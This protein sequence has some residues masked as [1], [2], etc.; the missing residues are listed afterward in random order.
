MLE[1]VVSHAFQWDKIHQLIQKKRVPQALLLVGPR[2]ANILQFVNRFMALLICETSPAPCGLCRACHLLIEGIHPDINYIRRESPT[3]AIKID[4]VR[5]LQHNIY[6]T[7]QR[8]GHRFIVIES[9]DKMNTAAANA[10]LKIL[11]EPP[12]HTRFILIAEQVSSI[13]ATILSRCQKLNFPSLGHEPAGYMTIGAAYPEGSI[14]AALMLQSTSMITALCDLIEEKT[15]P[16][17]IAARWSVD[18]IEDIL[19][20]LYLV[21]AEAIHYQLIKTNDQSPAN[22]ALA[23]FSRLTQPVD[24]LKQ[25]DE[26]N[27]MVS[28][29]HHNINMNQTLV[30]ETFLLGYLKNAHE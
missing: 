16:C 24:L 1:A 4:Q 14:R 23:H 21:H 5:E 19:W 7:P 10:L 11:E 30:L 25:L 15:S 28:K 18:A 2:H 22:A 12:V 26:I 17:T 13:P 29:I 3:S 6:Q 20:L 8:G 9:A 27:S